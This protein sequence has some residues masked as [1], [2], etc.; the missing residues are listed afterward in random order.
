MLN[1]RLIAHRLKGEAPNPPSSNDMKLSCHVQFNRGQVFVGFKMQKINRKRIDRIE[2]SV[3]GSCESCVEKIPILPS[4]W[5][6][7]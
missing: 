6:R 4:I 5:L 3:P 1:V 7:Q 2:G